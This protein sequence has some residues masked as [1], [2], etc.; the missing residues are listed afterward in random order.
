MGHYPRHADSVK[1]V[2]NIITGEI[3]QAHNEGNS[4]SKL[5]KPGIVALRVFYSVKPYYL[6][7]WPSQ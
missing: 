1:L 7:R 2:L 4:P 6:K 5:G 3:S